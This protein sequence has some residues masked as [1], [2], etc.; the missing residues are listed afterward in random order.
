M[1]NSKNKDNKR[2]LYKQS[3]KNVCASADRGW[4]QPNK[5]ELI[6]VDM[7]YK[8]CKSM[9]YWEMHIMAE[10]VNVWMMISCNENILKI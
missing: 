9:D 8:H 6:G 5:A 7:G 4:M 10:M 3:Y 2:V 1:E